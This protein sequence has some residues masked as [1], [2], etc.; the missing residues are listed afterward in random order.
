MEIHDTRTEQLAHELAALT[1]E[2]VP[3]ALTE[4]IR[5]RLHRIQGARSGGLAERLIAIGK[6]CASRL[7]EP[8]RSADHGELLYDDKGLPK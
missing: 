3:E 7:K 4:A 6:D 1:G 2:T 8:Y 5:E